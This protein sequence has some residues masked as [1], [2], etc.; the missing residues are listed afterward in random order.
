V[1]NSGG[2][3]SVE[4][5]KVQQSS[6]SFL[7]GYALGFRFRT[8]KAR[9]IWFDFRYENIQGGK[10]E[11]VIPE[12]VTIENNTDLVYTTGTTKSNREI[13]HFGLTYGF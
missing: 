1:Q 9:N 10:A 3:S 13:N 5:A 4:D 8:K 7:Y 6:V 12:T 2:F 11:Y